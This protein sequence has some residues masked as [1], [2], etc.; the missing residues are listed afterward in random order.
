MADITMGGM[1]LINIPCC[2][3]LSGVAIKALRDYEKQKKKRL[4]PTFKAKNI[5]LDDSRLSFWK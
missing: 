5:G 3:I 4:N 1:T 2:V